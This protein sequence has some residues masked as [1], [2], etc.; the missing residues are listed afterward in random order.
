[1]IEIE[2][3][4]ET[5]LKIKKISAMLG[6][7]SK[8]A[9]TTTAKITHAEI[10][11]I[12]AQLPPKLD[13]VRLKE[14]TNEA[15]KE[16]LKTFVIACYIETEIIVDD[17]GIRLVYLLNDKLPLNNYEQLYTILDNIGYLDVSS[18]AFASIKGTAKNLFK[19]IIN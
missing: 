1:M 4:T 5:A 9:Q 12:I 2:N 7:L 6:M 8:G 15:T 13:M 10:E 18:A 19:D 16:K 3:G 14:L 11:S 17:G